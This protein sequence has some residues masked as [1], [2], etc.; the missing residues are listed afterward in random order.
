[1]VLQASDVQRARLGFP[2]LATRFGVL[3]VPSVG[4]A[5]QEPEGAS[6]E[7][8]KNRMAIV[9]SF[10]AKWYRLRGGRRARAAVNATLVDMGDRAVGG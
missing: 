1:M 7:L 8:M 3:G 9:T 6:A 2:Y 4:T 10:S 5:D